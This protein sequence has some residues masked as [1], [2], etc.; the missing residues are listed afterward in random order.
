MKILILRFSAIG[1]IVL[2]SPVIRCLVAQKHA[3]IH[4]A[5][6]SGFA[7]I[8]IHHP[9]V[10]KVFALGET[11]EN[12]PEKARYANSMSGLLAQL[13]T[14]RYDYIIDLHHNLRTWRIKT[15]LGIPAFSFDKLN[16]EKWLVVNTGINRLPDRHIV[17]RYMDTLKPLGVNYD[18]KGL[19][20]YLPGQTSAVVDTYIEQHCPA[21]K[22]VPFIALVMGATH[23]TKRLPVESIIKLCQKIDK[24][25]VLL[26]GKSESEAG[27]FVTS[28]CGQKVFNLCG[29]L[30]LF[31]SAEIVRRSQ[32]VITHDTGLMHIAAA[33]QKRIIAVWGN[34]IPGFG[35][36]PFYPDG[37]EKFTSAEV[38]GLAC[39]PCSKIGFPQCPKGHFNCMKNMDLEKIVAETLR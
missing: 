8:P 21:L 20:F 30:S 7:A 31:E 5:T 37:K 24:P 13:K 1:D 11:P 2:T 35:M 18:G 6:K 25:V 19:D 15:A 9:D 16:I 33:F 26:G 12:I 27:N 28:A 14:V 10:Q 3:E 34:T 29:S 17:H 22:T 4:F 36:Y 39:R 38:T 23:F 32:L